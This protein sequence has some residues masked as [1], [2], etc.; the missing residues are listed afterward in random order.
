ME[1][2][3][4]SRSALLPRVAWIRF[5]HILGGCLLL[6]VSAN[7][8]VVLQFLLWG[9]CGL[10]QFYATV[11]GVFWQHCQTAFLNC[12]AAVEGKVV[13]MGLQLLFELFM[14]DVVVEIDCLPLAGREI[15][16]LQI[17]SQTN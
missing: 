6:C 5:L 10:A 3:E 14:N 9:R 7:L 15:L 1:F 2:L 13:L 11:F 8:T 16:F 4:N 12:V 17:G